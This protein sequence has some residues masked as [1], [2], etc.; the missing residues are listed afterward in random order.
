M[1][2]GFL[3]EDL[4]TWLRFMELVKFDNVQ[5]STGGDNL[6]SSDVNEERIEYPLVLILNETSGG[7]NTVDIAS[8]EEDDT[9]TTIVNNINLKANE[10]LI[11]GVN[12]VGVV[13]PRIAG[14]ENL[15]FTVGANNVDVAMYFIRDD[16]L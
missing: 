4:S 15:E 7:A 12:D 8:V 13:V 16:Y 2:P 10:T 3:F 1:M 6:F 9:T 11:F 5:A 14:G